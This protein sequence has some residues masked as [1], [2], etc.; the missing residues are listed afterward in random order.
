MSRLLALLPVL[1]V[2][3]ACEVLS[4]QPCDRY[5]D[6]YCTCHPEDPDGCADLLDLAATRDPDQQDVCADDLADQR[7]EDD[8]N[9]LTCDT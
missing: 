8:A 1:L 6:Y 3:A 9:G 5:A 4:E 2:G 7:A